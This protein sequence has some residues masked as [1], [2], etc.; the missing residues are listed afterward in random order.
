VNL[1]KMVIGPIV[2]L[3]IVLGIANLGD[4]RKVGKVGGKA[5]IY[6][7]VVTT[8]ALASG[9][10]VVNLVSPRGRPRREPVAGRRPSEVTRR[11]RRR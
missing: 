2:F 1:V 3:T 11:R 8:F 6:F 10:L 4:L 9:S 5:L 7:E